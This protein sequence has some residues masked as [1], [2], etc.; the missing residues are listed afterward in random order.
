MTLELIIFSEF[1]S[2]LGLCSSL[3]H[4]HA[5]YMLNSSKRPVENWDSFC[6][7]RYTTYTDEGGPW[8][9]EYIMIIAF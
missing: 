8:L 2:V 3:K 6:V 1:N 7:L 4:V 5:P 9:S